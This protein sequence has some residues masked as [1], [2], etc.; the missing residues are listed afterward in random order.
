[1]GDQPPR[2]VVADYGRPTMNPHSSITLPNGAAAGNWSIPAHVMQLIKTALQFEGLESEDPSKHI[3]MFVQI[4]ET[5][6]IGNMNNEAIY[7]RLFPFS[8][9]EKAYKWLKSLPAGSITTWAGLQEKF[10]TKFFPPS[11]SA[12]LRKEI[13]SFR[14]RSDESFGEVW[15]RFK[16]L[17]LSCPHH[18][19]DKWMLI[20][21][22][23]NGATQHVREMLNQTANR[24][25][26]KNKD[27]D[28][29]VVLFDDL[30][31][32]YEGHGGR[33]SSMSS[34]GVLQV[35]SN[36]SMQSVAKCEV[37]RG[38]HDTID[39][40][41]NPGSNQEEVDFINNPLRYQNPAF[42]GNTGWRN[43]NNYR[44]G[45]ASGYQAQYQNQR[46]ENLFGQG[47]SGQESS[48]QAGREEKKASLE[49]M[50]AELLKR[51]KR[52]RVTN[53]AKFAEHDAM[54]KNQATSL[55]NLERH[56]GEIAS[57]LSE[58]A[59]SSLPSN[60]EKNPRGFAKAVTTRSGAK[61][62]KEA[63][64]SRVVTPAVDEEEQV[65][66]EIQMEPPPAEAHQQTIPAS[67]KSADIPSS[68]SNPPLRVYK[69]KLPYPERLRSDRDEEQNSK[70]LELLKQLHLN[71]HFLEALTQ[72]PKYA[73]FLKDILFNKEK[74]A[75]VSSIPLSAGCS[76]VLQSKLPE[77]MANPRSFMIPCILGD[78]TVRHALADLGAS[79][80][81]MPYC[82]FSKLGLG[83]PRPTRMSIQLADCS[84]KYPRGVVENM[85]VRIDKFIS[86]V[87]FVILDMNED[88]SIPLILGQ[89][90]LATAQALIDVREGKLIMRVGDDNVTFDLKQSLKH[91]KSADDSLYFVNTIVS[92]VRE[93]FTDICG[94]PTLDPQIQD[95]EISE[96]EMVAMT[97]QPLMDDTVSPPLDS[98][99]A[100]EIVRDN[101]K[102]RPSVESPP[103]SLELK[104]LPDH[105]EYAFLDEE[106]KLPIIIA[107]ALTEVE[108]LK[109]LKIKLRPQ[110]NWPNKDLKIGETLQMHD[111][112]LRN[113]IA[114][115][116]TIENKVG[117]ISQLLSERLQGSLPSNTDRN[118]NDKAKAIVLR[119]GRTIIH[120]DASV[121]TPKL[122]AYEIGT[123][124]PG[125]VHSRLAPAST[126]QPN[127]PVR[128]HFPPI[129]YPGRLKKQKMKEQ[130]GKFLEL[131]K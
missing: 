72:M 44:G 74:L 24:N 101:P 42:G 61:R 32:S 84:V 82:V 63:G 54:L 39:C 73:I 35:D 48:E 2:R 94:G 67:T 106:R 68:S 65:D 8:L 62:E 26:L 59:P 41:V 10:M 108:K 131:F 121:S 111:L 107:T 17:L 118:P 22:F 16:D 58:R 87:D 88:D 14:M 50:M 51:D 19:L 103:P 99:S 6:N 110:T 7:L 96:V 55:A 23:Y 113:Q 102:D 66:E 33:N 36:T 100:F 104:D 69:P 9:T 43:Q 49:E 31:A 34:R 114:S 117:P 90:F 77:K 20:E 21:K 78:D 81:L 127:E 89:P 38:G 13:C 5:F 47:S 3:D 15:E 28:E 70:F 95:R 52:N 75:E 79:I 92:H 30:A 112:E 85:L 76:A 60:T 1:M 128:T 53:E 29:C 97:T 12:R 57:Q 83:E 130:Y 18:G 91:P 46:R 11:K 116:Q 124:T 27:P 56:V 40:P 86:P 93:F 115:M 126:A 80:N 45:Q 25:L 98:E 64:P 123:E 105:L 125:E 71:I 37:C 129:P 4:C 120:V 119:S 109:L 122:V